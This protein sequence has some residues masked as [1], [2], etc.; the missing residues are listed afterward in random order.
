MREKNTVNTLRALVSILMFSS[1]FLLA[2]ATELKQSINKSAKSGTGIIESW[3]NFGETDIK[4]PSHNLSSVVFFRPLDSIKGPAVNIYING[5]YQA[6]LLAG[7]YTQK[8]LCPGSHHFSLAYTNVLTK[9]KEKKRIGYKSTLTA[10]KIS[11]YKVDK[12]HNQKPRVQELSE[13]NAL[14][15]IKKLPSRQRHTI[16]RVSKRECSQG[17]GIEETTVSI[18][19][20]DTSDDTPWYLG[21]GLK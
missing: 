4:T 14:A 6:S 15:L 17:K 13:T 1:I 9:Y 16:S 11:Y 7:A 5:E 10:N 2:E 18:L 12:D 21:G 8:S 20:I 3:K 19:P